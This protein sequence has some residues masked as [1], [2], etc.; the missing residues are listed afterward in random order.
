MKYYKEKPTSGNYVFVTKFSCKYP[1]GEERFVTALCKERPGY[2]FFPIIGVYV[3]KGD[4]DKGI[5]ID[6][7]EF[8]KV[9][10]QIG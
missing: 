7:S 2:E 5:Y 1:S 4:A 6:E 9:Q 3:P 8:N 10:N